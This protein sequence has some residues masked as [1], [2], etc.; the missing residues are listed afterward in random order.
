MATSRQIFVTLR[1]FLAR[2]VLAALAVWLC[3]ALA[4]HAN[5]AHSV[6]LD[7]QESQVRTD[8]LGRFHVDLHLSDAVP[9]AVGLVDD[10]KQVVV[11][12][13]VPLDLRGDPSDLGMTHHQNGTQSTLAVALER[14]AILSE[15]WVVW[16]PEGGMRLRLRLQDTD[17][18]GFQAAV[19]RWPQPRRDIV[20]RSR[21]DGDTL[22][23]T[24]DPG[25]GGHDSGAEYGGVR[26][27][28]LVLQ[29]ANELRRA[30]EAVGF[31]VSLTREGD[32]FVSLSDRLARAVE[33][34][35]HVFISLH[36][37]AV[38]QGRASG[39]SVHSLP[40]DKARAANRF[41]MERVGAGVLT[42]VD[43]TTSDAATRV[44]MDL[45]RGQTVSDSSVLAEELVTALRDHGLPLYKTP[46]Q[47]SNFVV[48]RAADMPSV[49]VELGY[50]SEPGDR[51]KLVNPIWR[52]QFVDA[53][54]A[55]LLSWRD[56]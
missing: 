39:A 14:A 46:V 18:A 16:L 12:F 17:A 36:A 47:R 34:R 19:A 42:S 4:V 50:L 1:D 44:L 29:T 53:L 52:A 9:Y 43:G 45:A 41:V 7:V 48:L 11:R 31:E 32:H 24:L 28:D 21:P 33:A 56:Q 38:A 26:E 3:G 35:A 37:D 27:A 30:L 49:L 55:G 5:A 23:I 8:L 15:A 20:A 10:P 22:H 51:K 54:V 2:D 6:T 25:H 13:G 40:A